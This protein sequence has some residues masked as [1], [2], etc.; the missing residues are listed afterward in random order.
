VRYSNIVNGI[1]LGGLKQ[2]IIPE[3]T[4]IIPCFQ[5]HHTVLP[6]FLNCGGAVKREDDFEI[7]SI[8]C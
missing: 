3:M 5:F 1:F 7:K 6:I 4:N 2:E 8:F